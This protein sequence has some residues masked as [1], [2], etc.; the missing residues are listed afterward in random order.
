MD[1][2][3]TTDDAQ[4]EIGDGKNNS[5]TQT[6]INDEKIDLPYSTS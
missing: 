4:I 5:N 1:T 6:D 3:P 2:R